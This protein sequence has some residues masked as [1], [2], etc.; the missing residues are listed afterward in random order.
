MVRSEESVSAGAPVE[1]AVLVVGP[2]GRPRPMSESNAP[3]NDS[4]LTS[5]ILKRP[6][7]GPC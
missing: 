5:G 7:T 1:A 6:I 4:I 2:N 3:A